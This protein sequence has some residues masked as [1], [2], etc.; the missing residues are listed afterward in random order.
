MNSLSIFLGF[1]PGGSEWIFILL[2]ILLK[3]ASANLLPVNIWCN[4]DALALP[5]STP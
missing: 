1:M 4:N 3:I 5:P 2:A